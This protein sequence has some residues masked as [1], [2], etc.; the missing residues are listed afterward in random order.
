MD[1]LDNKTIKVSR[2]FT[3]NYY[4]SPAKDGRPTL[5]LAHGWPD[6]AA[7]WDGLVA[8]YLL[9]NNYGIV[10]IDCLGYG[11]TDKPTDYTAYDF[12]KMTAD[13][14]EILDKESIDKIV[15]TGHDWGCALAQR[16]YNFHPNRVIGIISVS[17][18]YVVPGPFD[19]DKT[20]EATQ[21]ALGYGN[22]WYWKFFT[23]EDG[24]PKMNENVDSVFDAAH[25]VP[26]TWL[27]TF[28]TEDGMRN[29]ISQGKRQEV[30]S[31]VTDNFRSEWVQRLKRD[32]FDGPQCW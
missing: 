12:Q 17:V 2:G 28:C 29:F 24:A 32:K 14:I 5:F 13:V 6:T 15:S 10:A 20:L 9:P 22:Y 25:G 19:L 1:R 4:T 7:L 16:M 23:A 3:Y 11:G 18:A 27:D 21:Q 30:E 8:D 31:Y 26:E